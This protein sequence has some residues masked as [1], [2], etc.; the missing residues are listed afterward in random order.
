MENRSSNQGRARL[1]VTL[2]FL[3]GMVAGGLSVNLYQRYSDSAKAPDQRPRDYVF[4][5][6]TKRLQLSGP[7]QESIRRTL[8][9]TFDQYAEI[10]KDIE[11]RIVPVRQRGRDQIR[12]VLTPEQAVKYEEIL[13]E[14]DDKR[15][16][17]E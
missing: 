14:V 10:K 9:E 15:K 17:K 12:A 6:L 16:M 5:K 1:L 8:D 2:V 7:Q 13:R 4:D 11:P 3:L